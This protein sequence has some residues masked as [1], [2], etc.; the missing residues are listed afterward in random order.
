M[1]VSSA[2][3]RG[4]ALLR[5]FGRSLIYIKKRRGPIKLPCGMPQV[6]GRAPDSSPLTRHFCYERV[7]I[8]RVEV[9]ERGTINLLSMEGIRKRYLFCQKWCIK[10]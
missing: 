9:Y 6:T 4:E 8:S 1:L 2:Y 10:G 3:I 7:G 5:Q